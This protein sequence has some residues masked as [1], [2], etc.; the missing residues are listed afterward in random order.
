[1][2]TIGLIIR[3]L[4]KTGKSGTD[5]CTGLGLSRVTFN[6]WKRG[7][8]RSY[9]SMLEDISQALDLDLQEMKE[10]A[11]E[12]ESRALNLAERR[13]APAKPV[14]VQ[15]EADEPSNEDL[16][17]EMIRIFPTLSHDAQ[18]VIVN[19]ARLMSKV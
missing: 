10:Q 16:L 18:I 2:S 13:A 8:S 12:K 17:A 7:N 15:P 11:D 6:N 3:K 19:S 14:P 4:E 1:M 5:L 9:M